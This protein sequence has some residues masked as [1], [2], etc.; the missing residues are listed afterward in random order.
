MHLRT[1]AMAVVAALA[2][3]CTAQ[4]SQA[5]DIEVPALTGPVVDLADEIPAEQEKILDRKIREWRRTTGHQMGVLTVPEMQGVDIKEY[6]HQVGMAWKL[7]R[8]GAD[9]SVILVHA[10]KERKVRI[11][12]AIG[13]QP[14]LTDGIT[15]P[16]IQ[17]ITGFFK[18]GD[19]TGGIATGVDMIMAEASI[20]PEQRKIDEERIR[21]V[22]AQRSADAKDAMLNVLGV[23][24]LLGATGASGWGIWRFST[25]KERAAAK[26]AQIQAQKL[27][28]EERARQAEID[29]QERIAAEEE[30]QR[31]IEA[32]AQRRREMLDAMTP[33]QRDAFLAEERDEA[34]RIR[35]KAEAD[36][37]ARRARAEEKERQRRIQQDE[38]DRE[39]RREEAAAAAAAAAAPPASTWQ[40]SSYQSEASPPPPPAPEPWV[41]GGGGGYTGGGSDGSY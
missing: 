18:Q 7:G 30:R 6:S 2:C 11:E 40:P 29:R 19:F 22:E 12:V 17:E 27:R 36:E 5:K 38:D 31:E 25:R 10:V 14:I 33:T 21:R 41:G 20:T 15:S 34:E 1:H 23:L 4:P 26:L 3:I 28:A 37:A 39:R 24:F 13:L 9:D 16:M 32:E 8:P 35:L